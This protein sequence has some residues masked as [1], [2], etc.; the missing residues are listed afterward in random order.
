MTPRLFASVLF[1]LQKLDYT[2]DQISRAFPLLKAFV[3]AE[4]AS[5]KDLNIS[6]ET[7]RKKLH[8]CS[9]DY[10]STITPIDT[11]SESIEIIES[12]IFKLRDIIDEEIILSKA[13]S[14][15]MNVICS[16]INSLE[17]LC[18]EEDLKTFSECSKVSILSLFVSYSK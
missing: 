15:T 1:R 9:F 8:F 4:L 11:M 12:C 17:D 6:N 3:S 5:L 7:S 14:E 10:S 16:F 18:K 2:F 13:S